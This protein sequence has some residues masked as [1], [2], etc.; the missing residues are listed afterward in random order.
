MI[1]Q[2]RV[3]DQEDKVD[4]S[5][6]T[7]DDLPPEEVWKYTRPEFHEAGKPFLRVVG[8]YSPAAASLLLLIMRHP[9][10]L[11]CRF[12]RESSLPSCAIRRRTRVSVSS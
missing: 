10:L 9:H 4:A 11:P 1:A 8:D 5:D 7:V 6:V 2:L 3:C 12:C